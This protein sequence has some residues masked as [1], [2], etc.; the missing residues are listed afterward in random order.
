M[1]PTLHQDHLHGHGHRHPPSPEP[2]QTLFI[3][4]ANNGNKRR[5][6]YRPLDLHRGANVVQIQQHL[7]KRFGHD[8]DLKKLLSSP[9]EMHRVSSFEINDRRHRHE[10]VLFEDV[11]DLFDGAKIRI[12][13]KASFFSKHRLRDCA[14]TAAP[15]W[16]RRSKSASFLDIEADADC[17]S[18]VGAAT[19][20]V[21]GPSFPEP[22]DVEH[23]AVHSA[24]KR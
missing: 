3:E 16:R 6:K 11:G 20:R 22:H 24:K 2:V 17:K 1:A 21:R 8:L 15:K 4:L 23:G 14:V 13:L 5:F 19:D 9:S 10:M 18:N 12:Q 7:L